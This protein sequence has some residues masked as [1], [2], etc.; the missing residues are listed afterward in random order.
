MYW[1]LFAPRFWAISVVLLVL[2]A[3]A[4]CTNGAFN[5]SVFSVF[6]KGKTVAWEVATHTQS[7]CSISEQVGW[8]VPKSDSYGPKADHGV[9]VGFVHTYETLKKEGLLY[10]CDH[11]FQH[12]IFFR[13][14][15]VF[16]ISQIPSTFASAVLRFHLEAVE[17]S[18][19]QSS[20]G[21][22]GAVSLPQTALDL[23]PAVHVSPEFSFGSNVTMTESDTTT[24]WGNFISPYSTVGEGFSLE[25]GAPVV[26]PF[27]SN[28]PKA[29]TPGGTGGVWQSGTMNRSVDVTKLVR[30]WKKNP[31]AFAGRTGFVFVTSN[32]APV[33]KTN[34]SK[35]FR[36][37]E[38]RLEFV[39]NPNNQK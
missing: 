32:E 4:G 37:A 20:A 13:G 21:V 2:V 10:D 11:E 14:G 38:T 30:E 17:V 3:A 23:L 34:K 1:K 31:A 26:S 27:P 7:G 33:N 28:P 36:L 9:L 8:F 22:I 18:S 16:D 12:N 6:A 25:P 29:G 35:L 5:A 39:Y 24:F 15:V 19:G